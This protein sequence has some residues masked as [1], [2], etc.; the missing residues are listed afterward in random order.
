MNIEPRFV[1]YIVSSFAG[2]WLAFVGAAILVSI[3]D[4]EMVL[5]L[6]PILFFS[7]FIAVGVTLV[8]SIVGYPT[9]RYVFKKL[10][11]SAIS[12]LFIAGAGS[13]VVSVL[14]FALLFNYFIHGV[15][16]IDS[17]I[18]TSIGILTF[19]VLVVPCSAL[20][21]WMIER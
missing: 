20:V 9:F 17:I 1:T 3:F 13:C 21:Y 10:K 11:L 19:C 16:D 12:K 5:A 6:I 15:S 18:Q 7:L 8:S 2:Y 4:S 14:G